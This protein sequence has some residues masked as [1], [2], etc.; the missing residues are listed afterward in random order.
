MFAGSVFI[1]L[2]VLFYSNSGFAADAKPAWRV[3][4]DKTVAMAEKEGSV[5]IY[6][7]EAGPLTEETVQAFERAYPNIKVNQLRGRGN[8]LGPRF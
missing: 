2:W 7:F 4:W 3:E 5:A 8:D 6:I 1:L